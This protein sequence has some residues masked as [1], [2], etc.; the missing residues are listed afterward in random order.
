MQCSF[1]N[2][3]CKGDLNEEN[4]IIVGRKKYHKKCKQDIDDM[5]RVA[6]IYAKY[7]NDKESWAVMTRSLHN[8]YDKHSPEYMLFCI[9][10]AVKEKRVFRNFHSFYYILNDLEYAKRYQNI[11]KNYYT[12]DN[13]YLLEE[14]YNELLNMMGNNKTKLDYYISNLSNYMKSNNKTYDSHFETIKS[15]Y[16]K[17]ESK[18]PIKHKETIL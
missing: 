6:E 11:N 18:K 7:Y 3:K 17:N 12:F 14:E 4:L 9:S 1:K 5:K 15:W 16:T 8:W 2:C 13:V 10:Q